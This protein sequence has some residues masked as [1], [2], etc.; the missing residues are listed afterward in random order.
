MHVV[1]HFRNKR[2]SGE[3]SSLSE[4]VS[5][6]A[7][8]FVS[9]VANVTARIFVG[10]EFFR[11]G[12][13]K[14]ENWEETVEGF[15]DQWI[16]PFLTTNFAAPLATVVELI[17]PIMLIFGFFTRLAGFGLFCFVMV[18]EFVIFNGSGENL[19]HYYWMLIFA[20]ITGYGGDKISLD[21]FLFKK[22]KRYRFD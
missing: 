19:R 15:H 1:T 2:E 18:I 7:K 11:S 16:V 21:N 14:I 17:L 4:G 8:V 9:P 6:F 22:K 13:S 5:R 12:M 3:M 10:L 20:L